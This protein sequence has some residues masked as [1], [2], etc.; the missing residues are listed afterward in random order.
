MSPE[1]LRG[2]RNLLDVCAQ[3]QSGE[4]LLIVEEEPAL[5]YYGEGLGEAVA[6]GAAASGLRVERRRTPFRPDAEN[7]PDDLSGAFASS[8]HVLFLA[9]IGDQLR[10]SAMPGGGRAIVSYALDREAMQSPFAG[11]NYRSFF[12]LK[13][14]LDR[15]VANA[16]RFRITCPLGT[17]YAGTVTPQEKTTPNAGDVT[18][19]R[20][21]ISVFSPVD[22]EN[23]SGRIAIMHCLA[24]T[25]SRY[26]DPYGIRIDEPVF[27]IVEG[28]RLVDWQGPATTVARVRAHYTDIAARFGIDRDFVHSWHAGIHPGCGYAGSAFDNLERWSGSAFGNPRL[29]HFHTCGD[30]AP[31]EICWNVVDATVTIDGVAIW[32]GGRLYPERFS[33]GRDILAAS[34]E[35]TDLFAHPRREIGL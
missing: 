6:H 17:D 29:L 13:H 8:D 18:V 27:A 28:H 16:R 32:E 2:V 12:D 9:R 35:L 14:A 4:S 25:G 30:Y 22:C 21:P 26:Y 11:V 15:L 10:F 7:L 34:A 1:L 23:F 20:F 3:A 19:K 5:G 31:G 33:E 24:G